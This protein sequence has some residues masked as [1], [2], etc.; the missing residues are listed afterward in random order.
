M[1]HE[2]SADCRVQSKAEQERISVPHHS[3]VEV[4]RSRASSVLWPQTESANAVRFVTPSPTQSASGYSG[5][6]DRLAQGYAQ[7]PGRSSMQAD[8]SSEERIKLRIDGAKLAMVDAGV[9][10]MR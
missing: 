4:V 3:P 9:Y 7:R 1:S 8:V 2:A 6:L 5:R 10:A